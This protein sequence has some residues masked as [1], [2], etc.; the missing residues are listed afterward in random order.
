[1]RQRESRAT[2]LRRPV[3]HAKAPGAGGGYKAKADRDALSLAGM[4]PGYTAEGPCGKIRL[5]GPEKSSEMQGQLRV[6]G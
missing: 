2:R 5:P 4:L 3:G 1:M 6:D